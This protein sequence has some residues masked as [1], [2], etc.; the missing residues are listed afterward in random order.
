MPLLE[1]RQDDLSWDKDFE[2]MLD[3]S[4]KLPNCDRVYTCKM[5]STG[6]C[7]DHIWTCMLYLLLHVQDPCGCPGLDRTFLVMN[8]S[9]IVDLIEHWKQSKG[10]PASNGRS[11]CCSIMATSRYVTFSI[12]SSDAV[13]AAGTTQFPLPHSARF[14]PARYI[15]SRT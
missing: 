3:A 6:S 15:Q 11:A 7:T 4:G 9:Y 13:V 5:T 2:A 1:I 14:I 12:W 8:L 10:Y